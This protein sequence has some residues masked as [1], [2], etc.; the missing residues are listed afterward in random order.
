MGRRLTPEE[1]ERRRASHERWL[2]KRRQER[3]Q[4][5]NEKQ[6]RDRARSRCWYAENP[7]RIREARRKRYQRRKEAEQA[8][9][10]GSV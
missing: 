7:E 8:A 2:E 5:L 9:G 6:E 10:T 1:R 3:Q 4:R